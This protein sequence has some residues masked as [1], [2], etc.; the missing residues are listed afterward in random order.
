GAVVDHLAGVIAPRRIEHLA[1]LGLEDVAWHDEIEQPSSI[2][3][4]DQVF[5]ERRD[6]EQCRRGANDVVFALVGEFVGARD[7]VAGP[8]S[9]GMAYAEGGRALVERRGL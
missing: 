7:D 8:A 6:I 5:I 1:D 3:A 2:A 9:P 4:A